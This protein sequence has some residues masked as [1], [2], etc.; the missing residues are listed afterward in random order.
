MICRIG[1]ADGKEGSFA[2]EN[3]E[4]RRKFRKFLC[5]KEQ[6]NLT[7]AQKKH[8]LKPGYIN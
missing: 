5:S 2:F 1:K 8:F 4:E 3:L 7:L 6:W